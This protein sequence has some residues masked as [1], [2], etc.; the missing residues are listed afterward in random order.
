MEPYPH[1]VIFSMQKIT[2]HQEECSNDRCTC[3]TAPTRSGH[4][5]RYNYAN[6]AGNSDSPKRLIR[7]ARLKLHHSEKDRKHVIRAAKLKLSKHGRRS[8]PGT[9]IGTEPKFSPGATCLT[10]KMNNLQVFGEQCAEQLENFSSRA[11]GSKDGGSTEKY[12]HSAYPKYKSS[13]RKNTRSKTTPQTRSHGMN[14]PL[15]LD[16][17]LPSASS[18]S[19]EQVL[20]RSCSQEARL[21]DMTVT[22]LAC[23]FEDY[24][25]IPKKMS[26]MAEMMYI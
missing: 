1:D 25:Y 21:D 14:T 11:A 4:R 5:N 7:E 9:L 6:A 15:S 24:V 3:K 16:D 17:A 26:S 10:S 2:F 23:Y 18:S 22:E 19:A 12:F 13:G 8:D 20:E